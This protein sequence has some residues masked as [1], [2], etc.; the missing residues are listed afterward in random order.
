MKR[1]VLVVAVLVAVVGAG[2]WLFGPREPREP[3]YQGRPISSWLDQRREMSRSPIGPAEL[4]A[5]LESDKAV[6][7]LGP[8]A[9]PLF[10]KWLGKSDYR[11]VEVAERVQRGFGLPTI[12]QS[13][14]RNRK[15][16]VE[17]FHSLGAAAK[18]AYPEIV[19]IALGSPDFGQRLDAGAALRMTDPDAIK[20]VVEALKSPDP[21]IRLRAID[22]LG[23]PGIAPDEIG[24][25]AL[26][27]A[28]NDPDPRVRTE[29]ATKLATIKKN[30]EHFA[31]WLSSPEPS[32]RL[33]AMYQLPQY[34]SRA[35]MYLP[36]LETAARDEN[37]Q[38][39]QAAVSVI[40]QIQGSQTSAQ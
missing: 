10:V 36:I 13:N 40:K 22:L 34:G 11:L 16:A 4:T 7:S 35:R 33:G 32:I 19:K 12:V 28:V 21:Q 6:R 14:E 27:A 15:H 31:T 9:V 29:A 24:L 2:F 18:S 25:P 26:E 39:R 37:S 38:V 5:F 3:T 8:A 17:G 23:R 30:M 1:R 20:L